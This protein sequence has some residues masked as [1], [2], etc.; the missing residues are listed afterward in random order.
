MGS[1][2]KGCS[3]LESFNCPLA[4]VKVD[5]EA[6]SNCISLT[7]FQINEGLTSLGKG[8]FSG[9]QN[10]E[11]V[12]FNS[13]I[14]TIPSNIFV[15]CVNLVSL[16]NT[17]K[18]TRIESNAFENCESL[19]FFNFPSVTTISDNAFK[20]CT[21]LTK[22]TLGSYLT[23]IGSTA[24]QGCSKLETLSVPSSVIDFGSSVFSGCSSL[25]ELNFEDGD[26]PLT[27]GFGTYD[28]A[29]SIMKKEINGKTI[30][31]KIQYYNGCFSGLPIERLYLGRN[32]SDASRYSISGDGGV[33]YY[34]IT[35]YDGPF[36]SLSKLKELV[37][38]ENV[39]TLGPKEEYI[40]QIEN[41]VTPG[42]FKN[43]SS[44]QIVSVLNNIPPNGAEFSNSV[45]SNAT[46]YVPTN[47]QSLYKVAEGWK[48]FINV[49]EGNYIPLESISFESEEISI[50]TGENKELSLLI[51]PE[52]ATYSNITWKSS[53]EKIV[54]VSEDGLISA[55]SPGSAII[56]ATIEN[57]SASCTVKVSDPIIDSEQIILNYKNI[58]LI[59][60]ES[61]QL[62]ATVLPENTTD[63][64][65]IWQSSNNDVASVDESGFVTA[66]SEGIVTITATNG[67][68]SASCQIIVL[69]PIVDAEQIVL[70]LESAEL[71][72]GE[73]IQLEAIVLPED[74]TDKT[75]VWSSSDPNVATVSE[76][77]LVNAVSEG[78]AT[79]SAT[80]GDISAGCVITV[81]TPFVKVEQI[82]LNMDSAEL[83]IG[84]TIQIKA[85][86]LPEDTTDKTLTWNSS[87]PNIAT[88]SAEGLVKAIY[89][90]SAIVTATCEEV[91]AECIIT[92]LE[93][94][95]VESLLV[96]PDSKISIFST[97]GI[98][99]KKDCNVE[100]LKKLNKGIYIIV[101]G[102]DRYKISI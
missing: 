87:D 85:I 92:V 25:K 90:G 16:N 95:G 27:F 88:V 67:N 1:A 19:S 93:D 30:Q 68:I 9:C 74:T 2:F 18:I 58:E 4:L 34:L 80:C 8:L 7:K 101:S 14:V 70:N 82:V 89:A 73:T 15:G 57:L 86:V 56:T 71:N 102:K 38:S 52:N 69:T 59:L 51:T 66:I 62:E 22:I 47:T 78:F 31:Y 65:V 50:F 37:I 61:F 96:N 60:G 36:C 75:I 41:Y 100:D 43:C 6:F 99:I 98:L 24:F 44:I 53:N 54:S 63:K 11:S 40:S 84:E 97:D 42:S 77:G 29:T 23:S 83:N 94:A 33:D 3:S 17:N 13:N 12:A 72:I 26:Q 81:L 28:G 46:L 55:I 48:E 79:I 64:T 5:E 76:S 20:N 10:L 35:S 45:Y 49:K 39:T 91:T 32:L 21:S